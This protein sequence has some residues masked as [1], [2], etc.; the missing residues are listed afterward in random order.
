AK[1][2][3]GADF[4]ALCKANDDGDS[5]LRNGAGIGRKRGAIQPVEIEPY[6]FRMPEG[7]VGP[8]VEVGNSFHVIRLVKREYAGK[9]PFNEEGVQKEIRNK[10]REEIFTREAKK[11]IVELKRKA[12]IEYARG[13]R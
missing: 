1:A 8:V 11:I 6:L 4:V 2:K 5:T 13:W 9:Q 3:S 12:V 10:L 7:E